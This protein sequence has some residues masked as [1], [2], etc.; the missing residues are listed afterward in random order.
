MTTSDTAG[1]PVVDPQ[2]Q[3]PPSQLQPKMIHGERY[4]AELDS[5][6]RSGQ[7]FIIRHPSMLLTLAYL[8][9]SMLGM[10][11]V[12]KLSGRFD[13]DI[14]PYLEL[15]DFMLAALTHPWVLL[16][17]VGWILL[18]VAAFWIDR[19][20]RKRLEWYALWS[21]KYYE[22][23]KFKFYFPMFA[24]TPLLFLYNSAISEST[25]LAKSI[26]AGQQRGFQLSL[27]NPVQDVVKTMQLDQVQ[28]IARTSSYLFVY[29]QQQVKVIPHANIAVLLPLPADLAKAHTQAGSP[30]P[31]SVIKQPVPN[32]PMPDSAAAKKPIAITSSATSTSPKDPAQST[33]AKPLSEQ[34]R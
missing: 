10:L 7:R 22:N 2:L 9:C 14:L 33:T 11:F 17:V 31:V 19:F 13:F 6:L 21:E 30:V 32:Q 24:V 28:I 23:D 3:S 29:H 4:D 25:D 20:A 18:F 8:L 12:I 16:N 5:I 15:T 1:V 34:K 27:I 26:K